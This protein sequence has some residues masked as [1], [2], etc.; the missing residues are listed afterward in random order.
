MLELIKKRINK[1]KREKLEDFTP[2]E[3][4]VISW[5]IDL[6]TTKYPDVEQVSI[7]GSRITGNWYVKGSEFL[8]MVNARCRIFGI[9]ELDKTSD[10]DYITEPRKIDRFGE[11]DLI[12]DS[13]RSILVYDKKK[14]F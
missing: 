8:E 4:E 10:W 12:F 3:L 7:T 6:I 2:A 5:H 9:E 13:M 11:I 1:F 14:L